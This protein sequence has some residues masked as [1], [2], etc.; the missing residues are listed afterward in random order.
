MKTLLYVQKLLPDIIIEPGKAFFWSPKQNKIIYNSLSLD[1]PI[2][3]WSMLHEAAHALLNHIEY[4]SDLDLLQLEVK[5][6]DKA[7]DLAEELKIKINEDHIQ[8][9]LDTYRDWLHRRSTCPKCGVVCI[10]I[11][12]TLYKCYN[13]PT[14]W[15][16]TASRFCRPYRLQ[17]GTKNQEKSKS[18]IPTFS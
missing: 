4:S 8:D 9:C 6:W 5:A 16:V 18:M 13:C 10:Q 2:G 1:K 15:N 12:P 14:S 17:T 7:N 11:S 3:Q